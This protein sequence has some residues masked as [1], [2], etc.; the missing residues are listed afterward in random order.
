MWYEENDQYVRAPT[1][2]SFDNLVQNLEDRDSVMFESIRLP[3]RNDVRSSTKS[4]I[5]EEPVAPPKMASPVASDDD[6]DD[7]FQ[8]DKD[9]DD[10]NLISI[11]NETQK[12]STI[13]RDSIKSS[14]SINSSINEPIDSMLRSSDISLTMGRAMDEYSTISPNL[15]HLNDRVLELEQ[16]NKEKDDEIKKLDNIINDLQAQISISQKKPT[17]SRDEFKALY[18]STKLEL[19][20]LKEVLSSQ[21]TPKH[22]MKSARVT[23]SKPSFR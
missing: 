19:D 2:Q 13:N 3:S 18:E 21:G 12:S 5:N 23:P 22:R 17:Q 10:S 14:S 15:I 1:P 16:L 9:S 11:I 6:F 8:I 20:K 7:N 4:V